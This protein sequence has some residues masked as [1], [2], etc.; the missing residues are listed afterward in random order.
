MEYSTLVIQLQKFTQNACIIYFKHWVK[1]Y[2]A[3][4][5]SPQLQR[6]PYQAHMIFYQEEYEG[7]FIVRVLRKEMDFDPAYL[8]NLQ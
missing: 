3:E 5:L 1:S 6:F 8:A 4:E 7:V 2:T